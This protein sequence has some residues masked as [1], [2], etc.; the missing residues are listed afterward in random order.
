MADAY[1]FR[2]AWSEHVRTQLTD[3]TADLS[4]IQDFTDLKSLSVLPQSYVVGV[5]LALLSDSVKHLKV[6]EI[7]HAFDAMLAYKHRRP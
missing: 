7:N 4:H 1:R 6:V 3:T 5:A 2:A